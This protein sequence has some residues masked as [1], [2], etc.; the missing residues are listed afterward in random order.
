MIRFDR[1]PEPP[2]FDTR[3]RQPGLKWIR[4]HPEAKRPPPYW[5]PFKPELAAGFKQLC[6]YTAMYEPV[7]TVD[8]FVSIDADKSLAYEWNNYRFAA[9]WVNS[10]KQT[11]DAILDPF[12]VEDDWFEI[13]LPSLPLV[14]SDNIPPEHQARAAYTLERLHLR[15]DERVLRQR[16]EWYRMYQTGELG[17]EGL[18]KKAPLIARAVDKQ[19]K[20]DDP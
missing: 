17:L 18:G 15:D 8:H 7:G 10:S 1:I 11:A 5:R 20:A 2:N 16:R 19:A 3:A 9:S 4:N 14:L 6:A 13:L 12:E